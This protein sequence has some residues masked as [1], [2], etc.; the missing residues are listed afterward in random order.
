MITR[1]DYM[2]GRASHD[3]YYGEIAGELGYRF[4]AADIEKFKRALETDAHMNNIPLAWWDAQAVGLQSAI[5]RILKPRGDHYSLAGGVCTL[6]AAA[7]KAAGAP[8]RA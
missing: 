3:A 6:K 7:R 8:V 1:A 2:E 5:A 4:P